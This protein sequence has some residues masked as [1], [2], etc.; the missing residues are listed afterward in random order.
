M[1]SQ[2]FAMVLFIPVILRRAATCFNLFLFFR[3]RVAARK[4]YT[5]LSAH[6]SLNPNVHDDAI[7][8]HSMRDILMQRVMIPG[9]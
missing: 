6:L 8:S 4:F 7:S 5:F 3:V 2:S 9:L 1:Q